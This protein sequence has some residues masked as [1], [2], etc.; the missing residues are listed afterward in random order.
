M[1]QMKNILYGT[2]DNPEVDDDRAKD[3]SKAIQAEGLLIIT[4]EHLEEIPFEAKKDSALIF[5]NLIRKNIYNFAQYIEVN[6]RIITLLCEGYS[7]S[8]SALNCGSILRECIRHDNLAKILLDSD[9]LWK[10]FDTYVHL[11]NFD[12][13]SDAFSTLHDVLI[14]EKNKAIASEFLKEKYD[15][16]VKHYNALLQSE[17]Y[18]TRRRSLK[19]LGEL[20]LDRSNFSIMMKY[21]SSKHNLKLIMNLLRDKSPNIQFEAFHVFKVFVANPKKTIEISTILYKNKAKL[22][23]FLETFQSDKDVGGFNDEKNLLIQT[24]SNLEK[25]S[26][27][28]TTSNSNNTAS[29]TTISDPNVQLDLA[30]NKLSIDDK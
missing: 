17:N 21:I 13:A 6:P 22:I 28:T 20:L 30:I 7:K 25:P 16:V 2:P 23:P 4:L 11:P 10:F 9:S 3:L 8:E 29:N 26:E 18:V 5:N 15:E 12:V 14:T 19:L 27:T 24:L 1:E